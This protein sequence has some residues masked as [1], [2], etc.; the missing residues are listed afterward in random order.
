VTGTADQIKAFAA[1][2][3]SQPFQLDEA[4]AGDSLLGRLAAPDRAR[5]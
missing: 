3:D 4:A 2:F 1:E 5:Q